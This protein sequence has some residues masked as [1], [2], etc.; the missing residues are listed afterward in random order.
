MTTVLIILGLSILIIAHEIGHFI[1]AKLF[2]MRVDEFGFGFPPRI[3]AR[4]KGGTEYSLNWLPFGGFVKIAG[5]NGPA[6]P[7]ISKEQASEFGK[8]I[9]W[10]EP[11]W[12][13]AIVL[14]A[15]VTANFIFGWIFLSAA[16]FL[17]TPQ[18]IVVTGVSSNSPASAVGIKE[19]DILRGFDSAENFTKYVS[20]NKGKESDFKVLR[21]GD[22]IDLKIMPR[23]NP[24]QGE[25]S[26]GITFVETGEPSY[27]FLSAIWEGL[28]RSSMVTVL[29]VQSL[30]T[31][32]IN[33]FTQGSIGMDIVGPVG[34]ITIAQHTQEIGLAYLLQLLSLISLNLAIVNLI[35]F[36]ALDGGRVLFLMVEK[37]K[38]SPIPKR[39]EMVA[40]G[41]GFLLLLVLMVF[42]TVRD[43]GRLF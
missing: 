11:A 33:L 15:G 19:G 39:F 6:D 7:S 41:I 9:F 31:L 12:K 14:V 43:I 21:G 35:P 38:G 2:G 18:A 36:P 10:G 29:I 1:S 5:E 3:A 28:K 13:R 4:K 24:P 27:P 42:V 34:I 16:L 8:K 22:R 20:Q 30:I 32:I 25:G 26:L 37:I 17:G 40:N 23:I